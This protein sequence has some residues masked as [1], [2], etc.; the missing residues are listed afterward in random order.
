MRWPE[1]NIDHA[2]VVAMGVIAVCW[3]LIATLVVN[4]RLWQLSTRFYDV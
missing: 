1:V 4:L 3:F 2:A